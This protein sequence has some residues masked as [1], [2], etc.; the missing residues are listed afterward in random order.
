M[1]PASGSSCYLFVT[2]K[3]GVTLHEKPSLISKTL[4][5]IPYNMPVEINCLSDNKETVNGKETRWIN[6]SLDKISGW[7]LLC[8]LSAD[9]DSAPIQKQETFIKELI[10]DAQSGNSHHR[11]IMSKRFSANRMSLSLT[12]C[13]KSTRYTTMPAIM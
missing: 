9:Y 2:S 13:E 7:T 12:G 6:I 1:I 5:T 4:T 3:D 10:S 11:L 8:F